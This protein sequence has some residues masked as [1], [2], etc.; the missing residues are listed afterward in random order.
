M[1]RLQQLANEEQKKIY[2]YKLS[3]GNTFSTLGE[4]MKGNQPVSGSYIEKLVE[5]IKPEPVGKMYK[6]IPRKGKVLFLDE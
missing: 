6:A 3:N 1:S 2:R 5:V 4:P